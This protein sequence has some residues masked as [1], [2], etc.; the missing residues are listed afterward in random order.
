M[1]IV[2]FEPFHVELLNAQGAQAHE[3]SYVPD[4]W[5]N[6]LRG[7]TAFDRDRVILCG[8]VLTSLGMGTVWAVL[9]ADAGRHM[10]ALH[11]ATER[12]LEMQQL[13][14]I[15]AAVQKGFMP[16]CRWAELLGFRFEGEM[17]RYGPNGETYLR[18][19]RT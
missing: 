8:G 3:V 6:T 2:P 1:N 17:P 7:L 9:S 5:I 13:R 15:E 18:Y 4:S 14:R 16:G 10:L 12:Y 11:R 19:G